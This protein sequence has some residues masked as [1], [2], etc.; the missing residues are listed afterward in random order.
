MKALHR[1]QSRLFFYYREKPNSSKESSTPTDPGW[2]WWGVYCEV[3]E[4]MSHSLTNVTN[5]DICTLPA[6]CG[7]SCLSVTT[8]C[9]KNFC[10]EVPGPL[11]LQCPNELCGSK[12]NQLKTMCWTDIMNLVQNTTLTTTWWWWCHFFVSLWDR[13]ILKADSCLTGQH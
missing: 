1:L 11:F 4:L 3:W 2:G 5:T 6:A 9:W 10:R 12:W 7:A 8:D 13:D